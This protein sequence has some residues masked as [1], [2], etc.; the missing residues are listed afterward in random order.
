M[1]CGPKCLRMVASFYGKKIKQQ[2]LRDL[3]GINKEGV[4]L[5]GISEAA[6]KIGFRTNGVKLDYRSIHDLTLPVILFWDQDHFVVLYKIKKD[7]YYIADPAKGLL[8][9]SERDFLAH[10]LTITTEETPAGIVL[11]LDPTPTFY[12]KTMN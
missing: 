12:K 6:E 7:R 3:C 11:L 4:S 1:D 9:L 5:L 10:W 8:M 2:Y